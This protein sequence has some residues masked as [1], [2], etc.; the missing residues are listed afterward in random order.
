MLTPLTL[1]RAEGRSALWAAPRLLVTLRLQSPVGPRDRRQRE[2]AGRSGG[3][4]DRWGKSKSLD[5]TFHGYARRDRMSSADRVA[6]K[7]PSESITEE[8]SSDLRA[9][10]A[11]TFS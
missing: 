7:A 1:Y 11:M 9:F 3:G 8:N 6:E 5:R 10:R 4:L 2:R